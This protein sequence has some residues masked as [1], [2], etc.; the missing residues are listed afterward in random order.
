MIGDLTLN[1]YHVDSENHCQLLVA[2][3]VPCVK[4]ADNTNGSENVSRQKTNTNVK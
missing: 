3:K 4:E 1:V 2:L